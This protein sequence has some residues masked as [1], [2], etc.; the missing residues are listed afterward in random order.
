MTENIDNHLIV[1]VISSEKYQKGH[2]LQPLKCEYLLF[3]QAFVIEN[4]IFTD[5]RKQ[6]I[7]KL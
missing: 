6:N 5:Q 3:L 7:W 1:Y 4:E 2:W